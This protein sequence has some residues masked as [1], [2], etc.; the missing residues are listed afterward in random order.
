MGGTK[1]TVKPTSGMT[2]G[3]D[4]SGTDNAKGAVTTKAKVN[5]SVCSAAE[6]A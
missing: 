6:L 3:T 2:T 4:K 1:E 5:G